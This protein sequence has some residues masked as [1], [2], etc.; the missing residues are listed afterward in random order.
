ME[1][2]LLKRC[3]F[4]LCN[5]TF[6]TPRSKISW[7]TCNVVKKKKSRTTIMLLYFSYYSILRFV[8]KYI[9]FKYCVCGWRARQG[10][11]FDPELV[12]LSAGLCGFCE[13]SW[14]M[15]LLEYPQN[16]QA[17]VTSSANIFLSVLKADCSVIKHSLTHSHTHT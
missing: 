15:E 3:S 10:P 2:I 8:Y 11:G 13:C 9:K 16:K 4:P 1:H 14:N 5:E 7:I 17:P 6:G 12:F